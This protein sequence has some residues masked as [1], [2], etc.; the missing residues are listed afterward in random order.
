MFRFKKKVKYINIL[1]NTYCAI[2]FVLMV[3]PSFS[4]K[5]LFLDI[6]RITCHIDSKFGSINFHKQRKQPTAYQQLA[7]AL[8]GLSYLDKGNRRL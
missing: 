7:I 3:I 2:K 5:L 4:M 8:L 1:P 6:L